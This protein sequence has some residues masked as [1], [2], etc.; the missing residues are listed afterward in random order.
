M[1]KMQASEKIHDWF[2]MYTDA[3]ANAREAGYMLYN[4][5]TTY[6]DC[7][8]DYAK[9]NGMEHKGDDILHEFFL[10]LTHAFITPI[11][12]D[13]MGGMMRNIDDIMDNIE[14]AAQLFITFDIK[15]IR[16]D[17]I[18]LAEKI[19]ECLGALVEAMV[20]FRHYK[21]SK[22][23]IEMI[24]AIN[25]IESEGD[26]IHDGAVYKLVRERGQTDPLSIVL[27]KDIYDRLE[28]VLDSCEDV[29]DYMQNIS[30]NAD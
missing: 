14:A 18:Q 10:K 17:A 22:K 21:K 9:I 2:D 19:N 13:D 15:A 1:G 8:S 3:V 6:E 30:T 28:T 27:W 4:M 11:D 7:E 26:K 24:I 5:L 16:P 12:R 20:E 29:A 23:L 25:R